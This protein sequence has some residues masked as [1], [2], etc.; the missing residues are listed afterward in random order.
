VIPL[1]GA[2]PTPVPFGVGC[3]EAQMQVDG[4]AGSPRALYKAKATF[5]VPG[6]PC[7]VGSFT[8]P[9]GPITVRLNVSGEAFDN[10]DVART[11]QASAVILVKTQ[12]DTHFR[13]TVADTPAQTGA[14]QT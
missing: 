13:I 3:G 14:T 5:E 7:V 12:V 11:V 1:N 2:E 8:G 10:G 4:N 6:A 9:V